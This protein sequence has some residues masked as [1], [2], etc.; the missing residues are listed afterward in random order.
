MS[1]TIYKGKVKWF[2]DAQGYGFIT[3]EEGGPD[4]YA[5]FNGIEVGST[6]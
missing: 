6:S 2:N 3:P 5:R 1:D 4:V